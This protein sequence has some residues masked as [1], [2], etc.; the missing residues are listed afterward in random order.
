MDEV[1]VRNNIK[2]LKSKILIA[3][4]FKKGQRFKSGALQIIYLNNLS[5]A[6][7]QLGLGATKKKMRKAVDRN[8]T[9][10][11]LREAFYAE[12]REGKENQG[13]LLSNMALMLIYHGEK[14]PKLETSRQ[15]IKLFLERL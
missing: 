7:L 14:P 6:A 3:K 15:K 8:R 12:L 1:H 9:K 10:R 11:I 5:D 4:L 2:S 13:S